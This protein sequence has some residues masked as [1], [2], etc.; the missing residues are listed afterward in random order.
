MYGELLVF[1]GNA[2]PGLGTGIAAELGVGL[3]EVRLG[4]FS[5]GETRV[6]ILQNVRGRDVFIVQPTCAPANDNLMELLIMV[7]AC[8]RSSAG[9]MT[10]V[11][12]YFGYSRQDRKAAPR[13]PISARLVADLLEAA[14]VDRVLTLDLHAAQIQGFFRVPVDNL[15]AQPVL[16]EH[17][18]SVLHGREAVVVAPDAGGVER[19]RSLAELLHAPL[20]I[21]DK[22][23]TRPNEAEIHHIIGEV[24][25][26]VAILVD[27]MVDTA[28]TM[29][30][31][32]EVLVQHG[33]IAVIGV[34]TH[35]VL[36][37]P[38]I[39]RME[40]SSFERLIVTNTIPVAPEDAARARID[41]VSVAPLLG[42]AIRAIHA[43]DSVSRLFRPAPP[44]ST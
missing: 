26:R 31:G 41:V 35:A 9:R 43:N 12:P 34:A 39:E 13:A 4:R 16:L 18:R 15:Y 21:V 36:S 11:V 25:E 14:G 10:V 6:E 42:R 24:G 44:S 40:A 17:V 27:D 38:A 37:G 33:A 28:G 1:S 19:A 20:A 2:N 5:D 29:T 7:E 30:K 23:R 8:R 3:G 32:A 22:R